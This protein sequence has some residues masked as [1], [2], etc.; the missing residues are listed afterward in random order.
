VPVGLPIENGGDPA[1][2]VAGARPIVMIREVEAGATREAAQPEE[3]RPA[4][5]ASAPRTAG[6]GWVGGRE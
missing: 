5:G 4:P 2:P 1:F 3:A 6:V